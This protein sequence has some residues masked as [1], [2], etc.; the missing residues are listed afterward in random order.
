MTGE[1]RREAV[2]LA[3]EVLRK[4]LIESET[5]MAIYGEKLVFFGTEE[6][7]EKQDVKQCEVFAVSIQ[8]LVK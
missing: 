7:L 8:D 5:S 6:Y 2:M 3:L 4:T 1:E